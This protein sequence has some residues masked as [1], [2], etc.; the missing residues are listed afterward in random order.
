MNKIISRFLIATLL[1][2][3][4]DEAS[5][6]TVETD[7]FPSQS[8][9]SSWRTSDEGT[10]A[11]D[12]ANRR[13]DRRNEAPTDSPRSQP[14]NE[15]PVEPPFESDLEGGPCVLG[16]VEE[17]G[18]CC[19]LADA[20]CVPKENVEAGLHGL[21][22]PCGDDSVCVSKALFKKSGTYKNT[23]CASVMGAEGACTSKCSPSMA[24]FLD[25]LPQDTCSDGELCAPCVSPLTGEETGA[26]QPF[27]CT[28]DFGESEAT[29]ESSA[30]APQASCENL[31][32]EPLVDPAMF[33][34]CCDGAR[35]VP[36]NLVDAELAGDLDACPGGLCVPDDYVAYAGFF[37]PK[38]CAGPGGAEGRCLS[39]CLPDVA[40]K[41]EL[42]PQDVCEDSEVCAP[43][44]DPLTGENTGAC[45]SACD[46]WTEN[47][48][49]CEEVEYDLCCNGAGQCLPE[50]VIPEGDLDS[51][52][53]K[54]CTKGNRCVPDEMSDP[55]FEPA[56]C[57]N[58]LVVPFVGEYPYEGVCLSKCLKI[59]F[60]FLIFSGTCPQTH[61][62][63]PCLDP[64]TGQ[65]TGAPG[66]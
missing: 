53:K 3:G 31:P 27:T 39:R 45:D 66:C 41:A 29:S 21:F 44:C 17:Y 62:C 4:C 55:T 6:P 20:R 14:S 2:A 40:E 48:G 1:L 57:Q 5:Q 54:G 15:P 33:P 65:A 23:A 60:D 63:V 18:S 51:L 37:K 32:E 64:I 61:D 30:V 35:C 8:D 28:G 56:V 9:S 22:S 49:V 19:E 24:G 58:T 36:E 12:P 10:V 50:E 38:T 7:A 25:I 43:C 42:L 16:D 11:S 47:G 34:S 52:T 46:A 13:E 26:C 59:P